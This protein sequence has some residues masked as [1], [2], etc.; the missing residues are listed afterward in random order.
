V[1]ALL[2]ISLLAVPATALDGPA[3]PAPARATRVAAPSGFSWDEADALSRKILALEKRWKERS[4]KRETILVTQ[5]ELNSYLN[6]TYAPKMP[7]GVT[8]VSI[9][10]DQDRVEATG[11][12]D[13][14]QVGASPKQEQSRWSLRALLAPSVPILLRGKLINQNGFGTLEWEEVRLSALPLPLTALASMVATATRST[15]YP[16]GW[17]IHAPF[18]LPYSARRVRLEP[19]RA[20]LE[21]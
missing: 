19:G 20:L 6:L 3:A 7:K 4:T 13:L 11:V 9:R 14:E 5:S 18:R 1:R 2:F 17:D 8:G 15:R 21:F 10:F 12:V 16:N